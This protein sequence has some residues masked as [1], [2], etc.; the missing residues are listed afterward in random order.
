M[1]STI[2]GIWEAKYINYILLGLFSIYNSNNC[3][4]YLLYLKVNCTF[5]NCSRYSCVKGRT[6]QVK[7]IIEVIFLYKGP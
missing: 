5:L 2:I 7:M 3:K 6:T 4:M 1:W